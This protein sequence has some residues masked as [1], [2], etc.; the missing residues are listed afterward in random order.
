MNNGLQYEDEKTVSFYD[1]EDIKNE[2]VVGWAVILNGSYKG[3]SYELH[4]GVN[5]VGRGQRDDVRIEGADVCERHAVIA[6]EPGER[7]FLLS[8]TDEKDS[9]L[10]EDREITDSIELKD[11]DVFMVGSVKVMLVAFCDKSFNWNS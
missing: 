10:Y 8:K 3:K 5:M 7:Q 6:Y 9:V 11:R 1:D 2:P 4:V